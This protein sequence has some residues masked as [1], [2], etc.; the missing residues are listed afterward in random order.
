MDDR[1]SIACD[2][3]LAHLAQ[4]D[5]IVDVRSPGEFAEDHIPGALNVPVLDD[6]ERAEVG[7][8]HKQVSAFAARRRGAVLVARN[9]AR[10]IEA[11]FADKPREWR[12]LVYC[13]RG[14][15]RSGAM[16]HVLTRIGWHAR[17]LEGGY[18]AYRRAVVAELLTL[19]AGFDFRVL[20]G[21][22][23]SGKSR[24]LGEL[25]RAGA[26]VLDLEQLAQ[27]RG[28]VLGGLPAQ[29]QPSQKMFETRIWWALRG[30][31]PTRPVFVESESRKVGDVRVPDALI[32]R[33]RAAPCLRIEL[34]LAERVRLLRDEYPHLEADPQALFAQLDCLVPL[35]GRERIDR[36]KALAR[37]G[38]W[39][40]LVERLLIEHYDPAYL[41]SI[42]RNFG[43]IDA[44]PT[45][46]PASASQ[47]AYAE[48][49][50]SLAKEA[51]DAAAR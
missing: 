48:L 27:H 49:A 8:L 5:A 23:G 26:Q 14:G 36:W 29:P 30:F 7:T 38:Q 2:E 42:R 33:M 9:V 21:T 19:P 12:P 3:A 28:S 43:R 46:R 22:T 37:R 51:L 6:A 31:D 17:Q 41:R 16:T 34:P 50:R 18:R 15:A 40:A 47:A 24:L 10:H 20:C 1:S 11:L 32:E 44:A 45:V 4:F 35:H 25:S 39:D 13:W